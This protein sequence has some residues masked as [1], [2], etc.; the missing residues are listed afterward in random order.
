MNLFGSTTY[1]TAAVLAGFLGGMAVG[2]GGVAHL[3]HRI[4]RPLRAYVLVELAVGG[5]A[6]LFPL[7]LGALAGPY[8][9][10]FS[11]L[12]PTTQFR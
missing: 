9:R 10:L 12:E 4:R 2:A 5:Y 6:M 3:A 8:G 7:L 11:A 1:A